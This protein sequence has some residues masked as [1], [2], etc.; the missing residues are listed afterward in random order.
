MAGGTSATALEVA[1]SFLA[2]CLGVVEEMKKKGKTLK[3]RRWRDLSLQKKLKNLEREDTSLKLSQLAIY[4]HLSLASPPRE[5]CE[6]SFQE[7]KMIEGGQPPA[8]R[9]IA[10]PHYNLT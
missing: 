2:C 7:F 4:R 8:A 9:L 1:T 3:K 10:S 6:L 5:K